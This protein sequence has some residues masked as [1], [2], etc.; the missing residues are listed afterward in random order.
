[1]GKD[2]LTDPDQE[3]VDI[4]RDLAF[5]PSLVHELEATVASKVKC[6]AVPITPMSGRSCA[7]ARNDRRSISAG[8]IRQPKDSGEEYLRTL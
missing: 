8:R 7:T 1:M 3:C 4:V 2:S 5:V 6:P